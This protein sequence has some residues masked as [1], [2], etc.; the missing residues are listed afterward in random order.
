MEKEPHFTFL[1]PKYTI[2]ESKEQKYVVR[3]DES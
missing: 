3:S 2:V 1:V